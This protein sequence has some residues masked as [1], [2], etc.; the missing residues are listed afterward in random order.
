MKKCFIRKIQIKTVKYYYET[1][2]ITKLKKICNTK[3][4]HGF[5][6]T[7][8]QG[9]KTDPWLSRKESYSKKIFCPLDILGLDC[10]SPFFTG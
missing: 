8:K 3:C 9:G 1:T 5:G 10:R 4:F 7:G 6:E 2:G